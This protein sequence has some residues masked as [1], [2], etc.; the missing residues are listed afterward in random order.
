MRGLILLF[1]SSSI[2]A[3]VVTENVIVNSYLWSESQQ[4]FRLNFDE[5][6]GA[7]FA[8]KNQIECLANS[9]KKK[10]PVKISFDTQTLVL[11]KCE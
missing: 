10:S 6:A 4:R 11:T 3:K 2:Y 5:R 9:I 8:P 7:Y 1:I